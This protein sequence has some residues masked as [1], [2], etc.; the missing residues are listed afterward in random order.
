M[1]SQIFSENLDIFTF[2]RPIFV[3]KVLDGCNPLIYIY[4]VHFIIVE[5]AEKNVGI[6]SFSFL[7]TQLPFNLNQLKKKIIKHH[8]FVVLL[9]KLT[10]GN[11]RH[12]FHG[13]HRNQ[14]GKGFKMSTIT[15]LAYP[16]NLFKWFNEQYKVGQVLLSKSE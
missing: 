4:K 15:C 16:S 8:F 5:L 6:V 12:N 13:V 14:L 3:N 1:F 9:H 7:S 10:Y 2:L 11:E